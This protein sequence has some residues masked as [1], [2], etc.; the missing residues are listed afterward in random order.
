[1]TINAEDTEVTC[2][3]GAKVTTV[4]VKAKVKLVVNKGATIVKVKVEATAKGTEISGN[5]NIESAEVDAEDVT[6][7][8]K[9][10]KPGEEVS[11]EGGSTTTPG[12]GG[13]GGG[14][15]SSGSTTPIKVSSITIEVAEADKNKVTIGQDGGEPVVF[16]AKIILYK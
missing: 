3:E 15:G 5:G 10:V 4:E 11:Y 9:E 7:G 12:S 14:G 16:K 8:G 1:M 6:V 13:G 2:G